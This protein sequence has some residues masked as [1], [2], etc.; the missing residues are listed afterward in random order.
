MNPVTELGCE[1]GWAK[2]ERYLVRLA[3]K[4][5]SLRTASVVVSK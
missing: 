3:I 1:V 2:Q 5:I 4:G